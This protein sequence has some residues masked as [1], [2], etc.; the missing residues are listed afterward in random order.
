MKGERE[1]V[2]R[3]S[4]VGKMR[5]WYVFQFSFCIFGHLFSFP[6]FMADGMGIAEAVVKEAEVAIG[7]EEGGGA[8]T[9]TITWTW[10]HNFW[11]QCNLQLWGDTFFSLNSLYTDFLSPVCIVIVVIHVDKTMLCGESKL[12]PASKGKIILA[13]PVLAIG[14]NYS[15][16]L[17]HNKICAIFA[18]ML[19]ME[20]IRLNVSHWM[21]LSSIVVY[22]S[23]VRL[24]GFKHKSL[25]FLLVY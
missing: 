5:F 9:K 22:V 24:N 10:N 16:N 7:G 4:R 11:Y 19:H 13:S 12:R 17:K 21:V 14:L 1:C 23:Y 20:E 3:E 2:E 25:D 6:L 18:T 15:P 8:K